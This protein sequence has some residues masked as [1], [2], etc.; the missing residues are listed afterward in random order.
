M[1][2]NLYTVLGLAIA[3][4]VGG[5]MSSCNGSKEEKAAPVKKVAAADSVALPNYRYVDMDTL[6]TQYQCHRH[7]GRTMGCGY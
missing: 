5:G 4:A 1:K 3:M 6:L 2:K 7:S